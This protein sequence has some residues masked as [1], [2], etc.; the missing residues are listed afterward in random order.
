[1]SNPAVIILSNTD[2][3]FGY[4]RIEDNIGESIHIHLDQFR[5]DLSVSQFLL[6]SDSIYDILLT[7]LEALPGADSLRNIDRAFLSEISYALPALTHLESKQCRVDE[8]EVFTGSAKFP[9]LSKLTGSEVF[10]FLD[11]SNPTAYL[12]RAQTNPAG[13]SNEARITSLMSHYNSLSDSEQTVFLS[14]IVC[15]NDQN[16]IRDGQHRA[17]LR[18]LH[19]SVD[20]EVIQMHFEGEKFSINKLRV[21]LFSNLALIEAPLL[22]FYF[23]LRRMVGRSLR[24]LN[25]R[26]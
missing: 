9:R 23:S 16:I 24:A 1:M 20:T 6:L 18:Y 10:S 8:L 21:Y 25:L 17:C 26:N 22:R 19:G 15:F 12:E 14:G 3:G 11:K 4:L 5:M 7:L 13:F 2:I